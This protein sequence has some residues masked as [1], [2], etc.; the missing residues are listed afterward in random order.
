MELNERL[1]VRISQQ[2]DALQRIDENLNRV[3]ELMTDV[4]SY[5][6]G[7]ANIVNSELTELRNGLVGLL[8]SKNLQDE[9]QFSFERQQYAR[10]GILIDEFGDDESILE[11]INVID[12][13][14]FNKDEALKTDLKN[15]QEAI[16]ADLT[17][18]GLKMQRLEK[19][20][21]FSGSQLL[22]Y[23]QIEAMASDSD[24]ADAISRLNRLKT[25]QEA[26]YK[27][28]ALVSRMSLFDYL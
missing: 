18:A 19:E 28:E 22:K 26:S 9:L 1:E 23:K 2:A 10:P 21:E 27:A 24:M 17:S 14:I 8:N 5:N 20:R 12:N 15:V 6:P 4:K 11:A 7:N 13:F 25:Q 16:V 3:V